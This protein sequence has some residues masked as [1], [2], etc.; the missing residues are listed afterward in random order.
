MDPAVEFEGP[1]HLFAVGEGAREVA[2]AI[3]PWLHGV[4]DEKP[5]QAGTEA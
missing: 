3:D 2:A 4:L 5:A 1:P